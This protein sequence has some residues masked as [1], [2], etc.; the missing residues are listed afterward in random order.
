V[1]GSCSNKHLISIAVTPQD[2]SVTQIGQTTQFTA[3][4][5]TNHSRVAPEDITSTATWTS[6]TPSVATI[7]STG[8]ATAAGCGTTTISADDSGVTGTTQFTVTCSVTDGLQ[9]IVVLPNNP[10]VPQAGQTTKFTALGTLFGGTEEDLTSTAIWSS[11][12]AQVATVNVSGLASTLGCGTTTI[13]AE[14]SPTGG[15]PVVGTSL[16]TVSCG[17]VTSIELIVVKTGA[18]NATIMSAPSGISCGMTCG[19]PFSEGTGITL[20]ATPAPASWSNCD[21]T[22]AGGTECLITLRPDVPGGTQ[23]LVTANY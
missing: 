23:K 10:T 4:G 17:P 13:S 19:A 7:A 5:T 8:L 21:Q 12:N 11:S 15:T 16:L 18:V 20:T 2:A 9:S 1:I 22:L 3:M 6:S 14:Y